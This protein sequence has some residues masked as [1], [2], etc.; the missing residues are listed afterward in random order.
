MIN[1]KRLI[2][3]DV[4]SQ[5]GITID[6][7]TASVSSKWGDRTAKIT[8]GVIED[9]YY[10]EDPKKQEYAREYIVLLN[11]VFSKVREIV[12]NLKIPYVNFKLVKSYLLELTEYRT[13]V[14]EFF[15]VPL[16]IAATRNADGDWAEIGVM[17]DYNGKVLE[18]HE[19]NDESSP[20]TIS[21]ANKLTCRCQ[22]PAWASPTTPRPSMAI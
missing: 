11:E 20:E 5:I 10:S 15:P 16:Y 21:L 13:K 17:V 12:D 18:I 1:L 8:L 22:G 7:I 14:D 19:G 3:E 2:K 9:F 4:D 6:D